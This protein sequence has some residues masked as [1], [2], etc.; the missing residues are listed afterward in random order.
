S[1]S[2][3]SN[4]PIMSHSEYC[5]ATSSISRTGTRLR[6]NFSAGPTNGLIEPSRKLAV[7][8]CTCMSIAF[9]ISVDRAACV[10]KLQAITES[11][12]SQERP[13]SPESQGS[14]ESRGSWVSQTLADPPQ[15]SRRLATGNPQLQPSTFHFHVWDAMTSRFSGTSI[16]LLQA[17]YW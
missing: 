11:P 12:G 5:R 17:S 1:A 9:G 3:A 4:T 8:R 7:G 15:P 6:K 10:W 16:W 14:Q 13:G 2:Q